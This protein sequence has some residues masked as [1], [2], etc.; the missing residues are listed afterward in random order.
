MAAARYG[1]RSVEVDDTNTFTAMLPPV[2]A[3]YPIEE[4]AERALI[5][6]PAQM[7]RQRAAA[8]QELDQAEHLQEVRAALGR[9]AWSLPRRAS[10][11]L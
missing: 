7:P 5:Q 3:R 2:I 4:A 10:M 11:M 6:G 1:A 8:R 9:L